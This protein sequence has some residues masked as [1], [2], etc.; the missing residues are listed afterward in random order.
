MEEYNRQAGEVAEPY[1]FLGVINFPANFTD[2]SAKRL[3]SIAS[4]GPRA[5]VYL[6]C[7]ID[8]DLPLPYGFNLPAGTWFVSMKV[9]DPKVW[10]LIKDGMLNGFSVEGLF[11]EKSVFSNQEKQI[12]QIKQILKSI[13]YDK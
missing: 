1:R 13:Q 4:N 11:A 3:V 5:G 7:T 10:K 8:G 9:D 6:I 2:A 12:N